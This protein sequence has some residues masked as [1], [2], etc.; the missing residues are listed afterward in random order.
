MR[1]ETVKRITYMAI[2]LLIIVVA[3]GCIGEEDPA[4]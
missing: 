1:G 2:G 3:S 4:R